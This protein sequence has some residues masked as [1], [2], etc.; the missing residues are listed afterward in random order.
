[1]PLRP[2][3]GAGRPC[4]RQSRRRWRIDFFFT[5]PYYTLLIHNPGDA[6]TVAMLLMV[7]LVTSQLVTSLRGQAQLAAFHA[8]RNATI[9]GFARRLLTCTDEGGDCPSCRW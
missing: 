7:G 8:N 1:L 3:P 2:L 6:V 4:W 5:E 9:A